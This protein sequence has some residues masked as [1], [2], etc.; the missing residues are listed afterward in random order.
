M[1][2]ESNLTTLSA[3]KGWLDPPPQGAISSVDVTLGGTGYTSVTASAVDAKGSGATFSV[4]IVAGVITA[5][6]PVLGGKDYLLPSM[7][8]VGDGTG[9]AATA[10]IGADAALTGLIHRVSNMIADQ[11]SLVI[12]PDTVFTERYS[13]N[14]K[15]RITLRQYPATSVTS[16]AFG[17]STNITAF[18]GT[19]GFLLDDNSLLLV[20]SA[21]TPG[22]KNVTVTYKA[23]IPANDPRLGSLEHACLVTCALWWKRRAHIDQASLGSSQ[24]GTTAYTQA[25]LPK[26][27][28]AI[29]NQLR[30]VAP[31]LA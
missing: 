25:D 10:H 5:I 15:D 12:A 8:I 31:G 21:F 16:V 14:G 30:R 18:D 11:L 2:D 20:G 22:V 26:E 7:V 6:T 24:I 4:T 17:T 29:I 28:W 19:S 27:A 3:L 1:A 23:G 13:G 9:A